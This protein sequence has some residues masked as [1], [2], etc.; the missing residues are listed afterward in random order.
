MHF[1]IDT[2]TNSLKTPYP[3]EIA[4]VCV[5]DFSIAFCERIHTF[6][7]M[8][9]RAEAIHGISQRSLVNCRSELEVMESF[10]S[11][12]NENSNR[13]TTVLVAHNANF[14]KQVV[15]NALLRCNLKLPPG[16]TWE[17]T[18]KMAKAQGH[19]NCTLEDCCARAGV[20]YAEAH[21][22]L[23]DA[24]MCARVYKHFFAPGKTEVECDQ[25]LEQLNE[26]EARDRAY[27][28][29]I[30]EEIMLERTEYTYSY[31]AVTTQYNVTG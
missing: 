13:Q 27:E 24:I 15:E 16:T 8:D 5:N 18:M 22:S 26:L 28:Q 17:C 20:I 19:K 3:I 31:P 25:A 9:P 14:D 2:E 30:M 1:A 4:A 11:F 23:P 12:L 7:P 6:A 29:E 10:I 21:C